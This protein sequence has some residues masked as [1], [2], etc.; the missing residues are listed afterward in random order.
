MKLEIRPVLFLSTAHL[1][2]P[3]VA[4]PHAYPL[5][6]GWLFYAKDVPDSPEEPLPD[7]LRACRDFAVAH[8]AELIRFDCDAA[9]VDGLPTYEW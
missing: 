1:S 5:E 8:G 2:D 9:A 4:T 3:D 7:C 6:Y